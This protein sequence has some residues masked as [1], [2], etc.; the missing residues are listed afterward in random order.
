M[1]ELTEIEKI[2]AEYLTLVRD[3]KTGYFIPLKNTCNW[4]ERMDL[5]NKYESNPQ[6]RKDFNRHYL[7]DPEYELVEAQKP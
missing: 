1:S 5:Y 4:L 6:A 3:N 2:E 7:R